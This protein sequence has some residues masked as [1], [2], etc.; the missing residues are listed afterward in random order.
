MQENPCMNLAPRL[1]AVILIAQLVLPLDG[2]AAAKS[3]P[4]VAEQVSLQHASGTEVVHALNRLTFGPRPGEV[5][6]VQEMGLAKWFELQM[7]P[8]KIDDSALETRLAEYPAMRLSEQDL[9]SKFPPPQMIRAMSNGRGPGVPFTNPERAIYQHQMERY[10]EKQQAAKQKN[11]QSQEVMQ[12]SEDGAMKP[13]Q[14][15][16]EA[17]ETKEDIAAAAS[18]L[19]AVSAGGK[20]GEGRGLTAARTEDPAVQAILS[21]PADQRIAKLCGMSADQFDTFRRSMTAQDRRALVTDLSPQQREVLIALVAPRQVVV[22]ETQQTKMLRAIESNRELFEVMTDFWSNHFNVYMAKSG[23]APYYIATYERDTIRP[24]A[25]GKFEDLLVAT[26]KSPAMLNYL[27]NAQSIGPDSMAARRRER[28]TGKK[29]GL[30]E[31]YARELMELHTVGVNGGYTQSDVTEVA[32]IFTGWTTGEPRTGYGRF[33]FD[34]R[35]HEPGSKTVLGQTIHQSGEGEGREVL[36]MLATSPQTAHFISTKLAVR[37]VSD[38]P[39]AT[40]VDR[41]AAVFLS[42][43]GDIREVLR[44]MVHSPEFWSADAMRAKVKTPMEFVVSAIRASGASVDNPGSL[45]QTVAT[46]GQP[47]FG[48]QTPNGYSQKADAWVSSGSLVGRMNFSLALAASRIPGVEPD[49]SSVVGATGQTTEQ[50]QAQLETALLGEPAAAKTHTTITS[51]LAAPAA[52]AAPDAAVSAANFDQARGKGQGGNGQANA[53]GAGIFRIAP[54]RA[55]QP[56]D[57]ETALIA[58]LL[59]GSPDFQRF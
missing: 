43:K 51:Q 21:L 40:L 49:W 8:D 3:H 35:R 7:Q 26:A 22:A 58:G 56:I 41:M 45:V 47:I 5:A 17:A 48:M 27:D 39:P 37:F 18:P 1:L 44:T 4:M 32:K 59:F 55:P 19:D 6:R 28:F 23:I 11:A 30:N 38:D 36:H 20:K 13:Q 53:F 42:S 34:E 16:A 12:Q 50:K 31:N 46:L 2:V 15:A 54:E 9:I 33:E 10:R 29:A 52:P 57:M 24:H 25:L 14:A